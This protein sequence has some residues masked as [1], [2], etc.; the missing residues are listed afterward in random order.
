[1]FSKALS[2][3]MLLVAALHNGNN[4]CHGAPAVTSS[5]QSLRRVRALETCGAQG[6]CQHNDGTI[7]RG[8]GD[9]CSNQDAC[10]YNSGTITGADGDTCSNQDSCQNNSGTIKGSSGNTCSNQST[11]QNNAGEIFGGNHNLCTGQDACQNIPHCVRISGDGCNN[12]NDCNGDNM[13]RYHNCCSDC[14]NACDLS[15]CNR[16]GAKCECI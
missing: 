7:T 9:T 5:G 2:Y 13:H 1:M 6:A 4:F 10:Q 12:Q 11:C 14:P 15:E 8:N 3:L 16:S